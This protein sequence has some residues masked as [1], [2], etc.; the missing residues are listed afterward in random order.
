MLTLCGRKYDQRLHITWPAEVLYQ[1][2]A[3]IV[4]MTPAG[5]RFTHHTRGISFDLEYQGVS[6]FPRDAWFNIFYDF[7]QSGRLHQV[8]CNVATPAAIQAD[9]V[10]WVDLDLDV[11]Q[12]ANQPVFLD[13]ED[14]FTAHQIQY[15]Y[16]AAII[17][18]TKTA[19][20]FLLQCGTAGDFP[21]TW[22]NLDQLL[23]E[24]QQRFGAA[25]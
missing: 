22:C 13:D 7:E 2:P 24:L 3:G 18:Q 21:F 8:Y 17:A 5:T 23:A 11:V 9:R 15:R 4:C 1:S 6:V 14:E 12:H 25:S 10:E 20:A 16:P 19:A